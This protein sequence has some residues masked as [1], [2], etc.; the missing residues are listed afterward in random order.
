MLNMEKTQLPLEF[1]K[2]VRFEHALMLAVAVFIAEAIVLGSIPAISSILLLSWLVPAFSEMGS[3]ALNDYLD[4]ES[5]KINKK[6]TPL[7]RG[8]ISP[9]FAYPFSIFAFLISTL[10]AFFINW[11]AFI[12]AFLFNLL[13]IAYNFRLKD[14]PLLGNAFIGL[15]MAIPFIFGNF[16]VANELNTLVLILAALAFI[17]GLAREIIKTVQDMEGDAK[18]RKARTLPILIGE[19]NSLMIASLLYVIFLPLAIAPFYFGL[20]QHIV[21]LGLVGLAD[22]GILYILIGILRFPGAETFKTARNVSLAALFL[23]LVAYLIAAIY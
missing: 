17:S 16:V 21:S 3:F 2:L 22:L 23:G 13:A 7:V 18:A 4:M 19:R 1:L 14:M 15:T 9:K 8:A 5:D 11:P 10:A 6:M 12:I 20:P